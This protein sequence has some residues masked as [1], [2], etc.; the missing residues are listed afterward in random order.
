MN[1]NNLQ[2]GKIWC[3]RKLLLGRH[4]LII[5]YEIITFIATKSLITSWFLRKKYMISLSFG[6]KKC[7]TDCVILYCNQTYNREHNTY[8]MK[9]DHVYAD[10]YAIF[11]NCKKSTKTP[12]RMYFTYRVKAKQHVYKYTDMYI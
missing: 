2:I 10:C 9:T 12:F 3:W 5:W 4:L 11:L 7:W 8:Y 1:W 6:H